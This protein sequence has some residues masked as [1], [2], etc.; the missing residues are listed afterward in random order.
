MD[1]EVY[2]DD[3]KMND[4]PR[5]EALDYT[6]RFREIEQNQRRERILSLLLV[7]WDSIHGEDLNRLVNAVIFVDSELFDG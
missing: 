7:K 2:D 1:N 5:I 3:R 6:K 4:L